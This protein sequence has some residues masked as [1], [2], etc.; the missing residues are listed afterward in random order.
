MA[1]VVGEADHLDHHKYPMRLL[2]P[3]WDMPYYLFVKPCLAL[4]LI[5][6]RK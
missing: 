5:W 2:R 4:G 6:P 3:G 1:M